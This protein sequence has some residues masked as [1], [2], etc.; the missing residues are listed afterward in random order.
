MKSK[1]V[2]QTLQISRVTLSAYVKNGKL[3]VTKLHNGYYDYDD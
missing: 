2:L 1:Q 3:K